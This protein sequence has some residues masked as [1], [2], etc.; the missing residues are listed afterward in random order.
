M[1][2]ISTSPIY[3]TTD[4]TNTTYPAVMALQI[5]V[6]MGI[7]LFACTASLAWSVEHFVTSFECA[8]FL[9]YWLL[10]IERDLDR[11]LSEDESKVI[12]IIEKIVQ[13][14]GEDIV[15]A[16]SGQVLL[17]VSVLKIW[18]LTFD[19]VCVWEGRSF[20]KASILIGSWANQVCV[21]FSDKNHGKVS[22]AVR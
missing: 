21:R 4:I 17:S 7:K 2:S 20:W 18:A 8:L 6:R 3:R 9:T 12:K 15:V 5:P 22:F 14:T 1:S 16:P 11:I 19:E 13:E 10:S